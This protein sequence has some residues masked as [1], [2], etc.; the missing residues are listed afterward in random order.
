VE[1]ASHD[2]CLGFVNLEPCSIWV[3]TAPI[4]EAA[5]ASVKAAANQPFKS[6]RTRF[7]VSA[8]K[9]WS[10][11]PRAS[12]R[13]WNFSSPLSMPC[14]MKCIFTPAEAQPLAQ[15]QDI[16]LFAGQSTRVFDQDSI[17]WP[18]LPVSGFQ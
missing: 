4:S 16:C 15:I 17:E 18:R 2:H 5:A 13:S 12:N 10:I 6:A 9:S 3:F 7:A 14:E 11:I 8:R 1:D